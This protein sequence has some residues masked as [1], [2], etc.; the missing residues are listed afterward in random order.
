MNTLQ[1]VLGMLETLATV[2][3]NPNLGL[4]KDG[5]KIAGLINLIIALG[6]EG[7]KANDALT[8]LDIEIKALDAA[9]G[10]I[11][12]SSWAEWDARHA[13]AKARLAAA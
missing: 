8:A 5:V 12:D 10:P 6:R 9:G 13:A 4:S 11:P 7:Q 3:L 1:I 2:V